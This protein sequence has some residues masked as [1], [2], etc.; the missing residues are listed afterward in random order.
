VARLDPTEWAP[1]D[2]ALAQIKASVGSAELAAR[3]LHRDLRNGDLVG[4]SRRIDY[5]TNEE[6]CEIHKRDFW[7]QVEV[8]QSLGHVRVD[9]SPRHQSHITYSPPRGRWFYVRRRELDTRHPRAI[10]EK[11]KPPPKQPT[12]SKS[13]AQEAC[14][15]FVARKYPQGWSSIKTSVIMHDAQL[16]EEFKRTVLPFPLRDVWLRALGRRKG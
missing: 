3:D 8:W 10:P 16:D 4:A 5:K 9:P 11:A 12:A 1:F 14:E 13:P 2:D 6:T 15:R 7:D